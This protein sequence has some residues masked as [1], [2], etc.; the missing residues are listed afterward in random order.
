MNCFIAWRVIV[1]FLA[2]LAIFLLA[3]CSDDRDR[4]L[5]CS[6]Q[7]EAYFLQG[8]GVTQDRVWRVPAADE[9]CRAGKP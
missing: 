8:T 3:G 5:L 1:L 9:V 7:G 4:R 2:L 6:L